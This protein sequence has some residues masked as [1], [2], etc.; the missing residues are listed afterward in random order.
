MKVKIEHKGLW[1]T[2][3]AVAVIAVFGVVAANVYLNYLNIAE[4]GT[5]YIGAYVREIETEIILRITTF[6]IAEAGVVIT[7]RVIQKNLLKWDETAVFL[8]TKPAFIVLTALLALF[9]GSLLPYKMA[10]SALVAF[11]PT[12]FLHNDPVFGKNIG[13]YVFQR[14]FYKNI[15]QWAYVLTALLFAYSFIIYLMY[16]IRNGGGKLKYMLRQHGIVRHLCIGIMLILVVTMFSSRFMAEEFLFGEYSGRVGGGYVA[17][18]IWSNFFRITPYLLAVLMGIILIL[19]IK[20][21]YKSVLPVAAIYPAVMVLV[22]IGSVAVQSFVVHPNEAS[23]ERYYIKNNIDY[24]NRAYGLADVSEAEYYVAGKITEEGIQKNKNVLDSIITADEPMTLA[25]YN[26]LQ[27]LRE[28]Y[29]FNDIDYLTYKE[30][31]E[32]KTAYISVREIKEDEERTYTDRK[33]K[34]THGFGVAASR[35]YGSG[36][37]FIIKDMH[38][39]TK[40]PVNITQPRIYFGETSEDYVIVN[41]LQKEFDYF[42]GAKE[43]EFSYDGEAGVKL[44]IFKRLLYAVKYGDINLAISGYL[45]DESKILTNTN[46]KDRAEFAFP[47]LEFD[48][49]PYVAITKDGRIVWIID[50][51]TTTNYYPYSQRIYEFDEDFGENYIRNS[52]KVTVDAYSGEVKGYI[53]DWNDPIIQTYSKMYPESFSKNPM[54]Y[55]ISAQ[56]KYPEKLFALQAEIY[57]KYHNTNPSSFY[58]KSDIWEFAKEK[59]GA[60][61]EIKKISPYYV[62]ADLLGRGNELIMMVPYTVA[63]K[64]SNL[65]AWLAVSSDRENYGKMTV[66]TFPRDRQV[67]GSI[68]VENKIDSDTLIIEELEKLG[69]DKSKVIRGNMKIIPIMGTVVCI[70]PVFTLSTAQ[71][72]LPE[73]KKIIATCGDTAVIDDNLPAAMKKLMLM[74]PEEEFDIPQSGLIAT[75]ENNLPEDMSELLKTAIAKYREAQLFSKEGDWVN[76]GKTMKDFED[77]MGRLEYNLAYGEEMPGEE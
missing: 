30:N 23:I 68:Q 33:F 31:G 67:N 14:P 64:D 57:K 17:I 35:V 60:G 76:Y 22:F 72:A 27:S 7:T 15:A 40:L 21:K 48:D 75:E 44:N 71:G 12:W 10:H 61:S 50:G 66:F 59:A 49:D 51:Y 38:P 28:N 74:K 65:T 32:E 13:Y 53:T 56:I 24:T 55:D 1:I 41:S 16:Y 36:A 58:S 54:P 26:Q 9:I 18:T 52:V 46:I 73:L 34:F 4:I 47:Y 11:N 70:E 8:N 39:Q 2:A 77:M 37:D 6:L 19:V 45:T 29:V 3:L 63:N 5:Q 43:Q 62:Q 20:K 25:A 69:G 42:D